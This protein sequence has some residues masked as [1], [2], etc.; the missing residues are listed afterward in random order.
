MPEALLQS[1]KHQQS[2]EFR[3][4]KYTIYKQSWDKNDFLNGYFM[5]EIAILAYFI[6]EILKWSKSTKFYFERL[7]RNWKN[8]LSD[9]T[10]SSF[11]ESPQE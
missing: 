11:V 5:S 1:A 10:W 7:V 8:K 3:M 6:F 4:E 2:D 9:F